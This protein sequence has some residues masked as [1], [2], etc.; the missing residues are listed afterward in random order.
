MSQKVE[1]K[2]TEICAM[3]NV[4]ALGAGQFY[5]TEQWI[6][7]RFA[8]LYP[9]T[10]KSTKVGFTSPYAN[11]VIENPTY[12]QVCGGK[13]GHI[14]VVLVELH[15][16]ERDLEPLLRFFFQCHDPTTKYRQGS[17]RGFHFASWI[18]CGDERQRQ[19]AE[20]VRKDIQAL[21]D[22][23]LVTAYES[24][25][26]TTNISILG[27]FTQAD[28]EHQQYFAKNPKV[29]CQSKVLFES[30]PLR[31]ACLDDDDT[32]HSSSSNSGWLNLLSRH[33]SPESLRSSTS[34]SSSASS[35]TSSLASEDEMDVD[36]WA[37]ALKRHRRKARR[38]ERREH[39]KEYW[40][41][42]IA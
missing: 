12:E 13:S 1:E 33:S 42:L 7:Q 29:E 3:S 31:K 25:K 23:K 28:E 35:E 16:P 26:V 2:P 10:V 37:K 11:G 8:N 14:Q 34:S 9:S 6:L 5:Q 32:F 19:V 27:A 38:K 36:K 15:D 22:S 18:F 39:R 21:L 17:D 41:S 30:W 20:R 24:D 40:Q 4:I